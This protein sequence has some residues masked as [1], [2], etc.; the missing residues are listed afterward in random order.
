MSRPSLY[1]ISRSSSLRGTPISDLPK[2]DLRRLVKINLRR[3]PNLLRLS[4][5]EEL[6]SLKLAELTYPYHCCSLNPY[7]FG[8]F[9]EQNAEEEQRDSF[10]CIDTADGV[11]VP[12]MY[13]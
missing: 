9:F 12:F 1:D 8:R 3:T 6:P 5:R 7:G 13:S 4:M 11:S 2:A 10:A